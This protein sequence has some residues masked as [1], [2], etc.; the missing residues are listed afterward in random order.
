MTAL[1][2]SKNRSRLETVLDVVE[3]MQFDRGYLSPYFI[4]NTG[5]DVMAV[6][7]DPYMLIYETEIVGILKDL[8]PLLDRSPNRAAA[9]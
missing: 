6:L 2:R 9:V 4:T 5:Q 7:D 8:L 1:S 3:G